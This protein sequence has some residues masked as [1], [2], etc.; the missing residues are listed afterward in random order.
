MGKLSR[1]DVVEIIRRLNHKNATIYRIAH[2]FGVSER[3]IREIRQRYQE[4][5]QQDGDHRSDGKS[6]IHV[7]SPSAKSAGRICGPTDIKMI[8]SMF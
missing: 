4:N 5:E 7:T 6:S 3:W 2:E 8:G 1:K